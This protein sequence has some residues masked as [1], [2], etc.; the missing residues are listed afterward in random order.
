MRKY[1]GYYNLFVFAFRIPNNEFDANLSVE[2]HL[3]S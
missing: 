1:S 2:H 3:D